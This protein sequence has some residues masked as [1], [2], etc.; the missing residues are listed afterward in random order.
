VT[1]G[2]KGT[3]FAWSN[4]NNSVSVRITVE[5]IREFSSGAFVLNPDFIPTL[6][7]TLP[8]YRSAGA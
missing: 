7:L 5:P 1:D 2:K 4:D 3:Y 8:V 6:P